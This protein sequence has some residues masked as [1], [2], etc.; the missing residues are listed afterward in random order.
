VKY[1][2]KIFLINLCIVLTI[3]CAF[4]MGY[5]FG[6]MKYANILKDPVNFCK[7]AMLQIFINE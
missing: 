1:I 6:V 7:E 4:L 2:S 5:S 3:I